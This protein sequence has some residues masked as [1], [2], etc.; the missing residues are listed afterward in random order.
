MMRYNQA[1]QNSMKVPFEFQP[2][3]LE[4]LHSLVNGL[5]YKCMHSIF[6]ESGGKISDEDLAALEQEISK[7]FFTVRQ[8]IQS[9]PNLKK[10]FGYLYDDSS[11]TYYEFG[12]SAVIRMAKVFEDKHKDAKTKGFIGI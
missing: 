4:F 6:L 1:L 3:T 2:S 7:D 10:T 9:N 8:L 12:I 5:A 11:A